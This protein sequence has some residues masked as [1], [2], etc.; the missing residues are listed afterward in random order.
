MK[1]TVLTLVAA[2]ALL[3]T[4]CA[5]QDRTAGSVSF[6]LEEG[7][8]A[9]VLTKGS[10]SDYASLPDAADFSLTVKNSLGATIYNGLLGAWN[11]DAPLAAGNY[12]AQVEYGDPSAEGP[13]KPCF[14]G[15]ASFGVLGGQNTNVKVTVNL[16]NCIVKIDCSEAFKNYFPERSF[17]ISTP[18]SAGGFTYGDK[19][20]FVAYQWTVSG[21]LKTQAGVSYDLPERTFKG[22]AAT[23]Y[24]VKYDISNVGGVTITISFNDNVQTVKLGD[25][26][27]NS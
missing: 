4:S 11:A 23:C 21:A 2:L 26:E 15:S 27:L 8:V 6:S 7:A 13:G 25:V 10:V 17:V 1:K 16:A 19:A 3:A 14:E 5:K 12:S 24:T 9:E 22:D 20:I 18:E